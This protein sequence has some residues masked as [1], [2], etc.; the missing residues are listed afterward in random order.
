MKFD[1]FVNKKK[2][3]KIL[4]WLGIS[5]F[6]VIGLCSAIVYFNSDKIKQTFIKE[7]NKHLLTEVKVKDIDIGWMSS[8]PLVSVSFS[9]ISIADAYKDT[10]LNQGTMASLSNLS[11][12]FN[13]IDVLSGSYNI[14]K[15]EAEKGQI[16]LRILN[17]GDCN[18][19]FW[20]SD[21]SSSDSEF[22]FSIK[23][24]QIKDI[25]SGGFDYG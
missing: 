6:A 12:K 4:F 17:T 21:T 5:L 3:T 20:K 19:E 7:L 10:T 14:R 25:I 9:Q 18:Y 16:K 23:K 24:V 1:S 8:F 11:L 2:F 15:I 22:S 13:L